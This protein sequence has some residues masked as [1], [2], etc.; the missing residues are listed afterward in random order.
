MFQSY[1]QYPRIRLDLTTN[2]HFEVWICLGSW[3]IW[4]GSDEGEFMRYLCHSI[5]ARC[6][7]IR[8]CRAWRDVDLLSES[9]NRAVVSAKPEMRRGECASS[10]HVSTGRTL[11]LTIRPRGPMFVF[12]VYRYCSVA[13]FILRG[14]CKQYRK[15]CLCV[16]M[17]MCMYHW[18]PL[19]GAWVH[20]QSS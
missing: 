12:T 7:I 14:I 19:S 18:L 2:H 9:G 5:L 3:S 20:I 17:C 4:V 15:V 16:C 8:F 6:I 11:V 1:L 13:K 10:F